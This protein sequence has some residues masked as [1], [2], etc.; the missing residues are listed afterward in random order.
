MRKQGY[1][2]S[3][4]ESTVV[5]R[6]LKTVF[7]RFIAPIKPFENLSVFDKILSLPERPNTTNSRDN[8]RLEG[9]ISQLFKGRVLL[10]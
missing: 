2:Q 5:G 4:I 6:V 7:L 8:E 3:Y 9:R 10:S 1:K